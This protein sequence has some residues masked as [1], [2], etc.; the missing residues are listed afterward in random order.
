MASSN[1]KQIYQSLITENSSNCDFTYIKLQNLTENS[2]RE[3]VLS[4]AD[5]QVKFDT[6][7][8]F[9]NVNQ[10]VPTMRSRGHSHK[11]LKHKMWRI[12][13]TGS[14]I[15]RYEKLFWSFFMT[16][17]RNVIIIN[18]LYRNINFSCNCE[19]HVLFN[20]MSIKRLF[21][22]IECALLPLLAHKNFNYYIIKQKEIL[23]KSLMENYD[24]KAK[25]DFLYKKLLNSDDG[26]HFTPRAALN[27]AR[28]LQ[29]RID[30]MHTREAAAQQSSNQGMVITKT[31][32]N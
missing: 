11:N 18:H 16:G 13:R 32:T 14:L 1:G 15:E 24:K 4:I 17:V 19:N 20:I 23:R 5:L 25:L 26:L 28:H 30:K 7:V 31:T 9:L 21:N 10:L 6:A 2:I 12:Q 22:R 27:F 8:L 3:A 29:Y